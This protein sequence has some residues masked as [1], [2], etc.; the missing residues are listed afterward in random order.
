SLQRRFELKVQNFQCKNYSSLLRHLN[1]DLTK[2]STGR[3]Y[4]DFE[5][6]LQRNLDKDA[7]VHI[8]SFFTPQ[9]AKKAV[10]FLDLN[11][12]ICDVLKDTNS[13]SIM[14]TILA[15]LRKTSN[16]PYSC[17]IKA[18]FKYNFINF[19]LDADTLPPYTPLMSY[20]FTVKYYENK[21]LLLTMDV[22]GSTVSRSESN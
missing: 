15:E 2:I 19:T 10:K 17:P 14:K 4:I 1:C 5:F 12:K 18:N 20:N 13:L 3:Y 16:L 21:K 8:T 22:D 6:E 7:R 9:N 11:L